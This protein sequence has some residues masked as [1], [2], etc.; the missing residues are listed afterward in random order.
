MVLGEKKLNN[1][2]VI[3]WTRET[4]HRTTVKRLWKPSGRMA[5]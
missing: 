1:E 2:L 3:V 4:H 5:T